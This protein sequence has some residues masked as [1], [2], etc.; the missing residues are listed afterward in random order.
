MLGAESLDPDDPLHDFF[1]ERY[2]TGRQFVRALLDDEKAQ[3]RV[4]QDVDVDQIALEVMATIMGVE[5]QWLTDPERVDMA[6]AMETYIDQLIERLAP[7]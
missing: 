5:Y 6:G 7:R 4:R 1:A 3:G 2:E